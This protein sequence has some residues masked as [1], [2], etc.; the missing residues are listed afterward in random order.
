MYFLSCG[1]DFVSKQ[2]LE[3]KKTGISN[4]AGEVALLA[5]L[6]MWIATIPRNRR[7]VFELFFYTHY[8]YTLFI[9][10]FIFHVGIFYACTILPCFYLFLVDRYLRFLQSRRRVRLVSSASRDFT[11]CKI[12]GAKYFEVVN[13]RLHPIKQ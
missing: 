5:G 8:L 12:K 1:Y 3:W 4:V 9:V 2:M 7:K 13:Q 6:S 10:F 11:Y